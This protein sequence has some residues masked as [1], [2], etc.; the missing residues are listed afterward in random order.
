MVKTIATL[1][2]YS[3]VLL[4]ALTICTGIAWLMVEAFNIFAVNDV[5]P[6]TTQYIFLG[7]L[8]YLIFP[9]GSRKHE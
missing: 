6:T 5:H 7:V 1:L 9:K 3:F 2:A 4:I 8:L